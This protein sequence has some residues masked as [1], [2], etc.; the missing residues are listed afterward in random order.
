ML[1]RFSLW[2]H[3]AVEPPCAQQADEVVSEHTVPL[4]LG[5]LASHLPSHAETSIVTSTTM[6]KHQL[7]YLYSHLTFER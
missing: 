4:R 5:R 1:E 7:P 2:I 3:A 6:E